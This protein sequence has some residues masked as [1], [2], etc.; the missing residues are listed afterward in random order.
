MNEFHQCRMKK[1]VFYL[2]LSTLLTHELDAMSNHEWRVMPVLR[3]LPDDIGMLVFVAIHVPILAGLLTLVASP[4]PSTRSLTRLGVSAFLVTH[5]L[6]HF[7]F[8]GYPGYEFS[9]LISKILIFG[10]AALGIIYLAL[11]GRDKCER[12]G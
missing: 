12:A 5:G 8:I 4:N 7:L 9:S 6:L 11:E 10:G 3:A 1:F 2:G